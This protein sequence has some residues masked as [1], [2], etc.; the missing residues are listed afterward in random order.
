VS[1]R[2][3]ST[4]IVLAVELLRQLIENDALDTA[5]AQAREILTALEVRRGSNET[6]LG[7]RSMDDLVESEDQGG[8]RQRI[9]E[10]EAQ[11][12][13]WATAVRVAQAR[14]SGEQ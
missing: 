4:S 12:R 6:I 8:D 7:A 5:V 14:A 2:A 3:T 9:A 11:L 13:G 1:S 10:L